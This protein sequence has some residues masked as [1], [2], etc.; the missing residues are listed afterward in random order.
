MFWAAL[1]LGVVL[2]AAWD[3]GENARSRPSCRLWSVDES[4]N[5][6]LRPYV[7]PGK[8]YG[9]FL[10]GGQ[11]PVFADEVPRLYF[12]APSEE[13]LHLVLLADSSSAEDREWVRRV[14]AIYDADAKASLPTLALIVLPCAHENAPRSIDDVVIA[15]HYVA[16]QTRTLPLLLSEISHS[17]MPPELDHMRDFLQIT[18]PDILSRVDVFLQQQRPHID[19][20][21]KIASAQRNRSGAVLAC[22]ESAQL[23]SM[24]QVLTGSPTHQELAVFLHQAKATQDAYLSSSIGRIPVI[25][26]SGCDCADLMHPHGPPP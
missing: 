17:S 26:P 7:T 9:V 19:K 1:L 18:E 4:K 24:R 21:W 25:P 10:D 15:T 3:R 22:H 2:L 23:I 13:P 20:V 8:V 12:G 16:N 14:Q 5:A 6:L 11:A